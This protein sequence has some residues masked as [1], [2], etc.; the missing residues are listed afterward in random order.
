M[1]LVLRLIHNGRMRR[2]RSGTWVHW[3][4]I[5][6][7]DRRMLLLGMLWKRLVLLLRVLELLRM[8][9]VLY[10]EHSNAIDR[11]QNQVLRQQH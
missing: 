3:R 11:R 8:L 5:L 10:F 9:S 2:M 6:C 4:H 1:L 7:L